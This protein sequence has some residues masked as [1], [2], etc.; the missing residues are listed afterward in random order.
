L[1]EDLK[2][3]SVFTV[4]YTPDGAEKLETLNSKTG[5][6]STAIKLS[7]LKGVP[8]FN[9]KNESSIERFKAFMNDNYPTV[10]KT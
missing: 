10:L 7:L 4:C 6:T 8:V 2:T 5:G 1:G 3:P 9:F